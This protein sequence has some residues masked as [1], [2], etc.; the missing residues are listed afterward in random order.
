MSGYTGA[1]GRLTRRQARILALVRD[2]R[3]VPDIAVRLRLSLEVVADEVTTINARI[4]AR[5]ALRQVSRPTSVLL[6]T[7]EQQV[8]EA[9]AEGLTAEQI[10]RRLHLSRE[11]VR[12][13]VKTLRQKLGAADRAHAVTLGFR[14]GVL[15]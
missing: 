7:R 11:T 6:S 10:G 4:D 13:H 8:L 9:V 12:S 5:R 14:A 1:A 3:N 15:Q 2:G